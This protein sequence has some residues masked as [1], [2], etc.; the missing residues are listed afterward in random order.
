MEVLIRQGV[1]TSETCHQLTP[2]VIQDAFW[3]EIGFPPSLKTSNLGIAKYECCQDEL[4]CLLAFVLW[5][6]LA[7]L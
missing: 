7:Q 6:K 4:Q 5:L 3:Y 1:L 2:H